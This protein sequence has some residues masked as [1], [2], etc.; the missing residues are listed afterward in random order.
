MARDR[1]QDP[2][3]I[4]RQPACELPLRWDARHH[5]GQTFRRFVSV[6]QR[7]DV[8]GGRA[9][10]LEQDAFGREFVSDA[11]RLGEVPVFLGL[12]ACRDPFLDPARIAATLEPFRLRNGQ[13]PE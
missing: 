2:R 7:D 12:S 5:S 13:Q 6:R 1:Q 8:R 9:V 3:P 4:L 11:I 10:W